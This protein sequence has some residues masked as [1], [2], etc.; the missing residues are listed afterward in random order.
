MVAD[1]AT[2]ISHKVSLGNSLERVLPYLTKHDDGWNR[3]RHLHNHIGKHANPLTP[4]YGCACCDAKSY[5]GGNCCPMCVAAGTL[6]LVCVNYKLK[7]RAYGSKLH[8]WWWPWTPAHRAFKRAQAKSKNSGWVGY[9]PQ[10]W[11]G[12]K[13]QL[14]LPDNV[15]NRNHAKASGYQPQ[16]ASWQ[17]GQRATPDHVPNLD[18]AN[19]WEGFVPGPAGKSLTQSSQQPETASSSSTGPGN[20][21]EDATKA[22][23]WFVVEL[24]QMD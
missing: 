13:R 12:P 5:S 22:D 16:Q 2:A 23:D 11:P 9:E 20:R 14:A 15:P 18:R 19:P 7:V 3:D 1:S 8:A 24:E 21:T 6:S 4:V 17:Q 10:I